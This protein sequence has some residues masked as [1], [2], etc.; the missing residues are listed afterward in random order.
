MSTSK[1]NINVAMEL[2]PFKVALG[3]VFDKVVND[4]KAKLGRWEIGE[5]GQNNVKSTQGRVKFGS[6][7]ITSK[8]GH[9][10]AYP[11]N[12]V[13]AILMRFGNQLV[14][15]GMSAGTITL[16]AAGTDIEYC[17]IQADIPQPCQAWITEQKQLLRNKS[18]DAVPTIAKV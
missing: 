2:T 16:N 6:K 18:T 14:D 15:L 10:L 17:G 13:T 7:F 3:P 9:K 11:L 5:N 1:F 4:C 12:D 8:D